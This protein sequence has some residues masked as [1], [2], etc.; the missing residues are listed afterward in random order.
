V[1]T[2]KRTRDEI[3]KLGGEL[4]ER[5]IKPSLRPEDHGKFV[6]IDVDSGDYELNEDDYLAVTRLLDRKPAADS[7]LMRVG[8]PTTYKMRLGR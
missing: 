7:L 8:Y 1:P 6:A 3:A 2:T 5:Q 4:F